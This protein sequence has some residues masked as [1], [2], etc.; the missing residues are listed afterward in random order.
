MLALRALFQAIRCPPL[1][2]ETQLTDNDWQDVTPPQKHLNDRVIRLPRG[3]V[4]GGC[5]STKGS[6]AGSARLLL[7]DLWL[8]AEGGL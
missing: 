1:F 6:W 4:L 2:M 7:L 3:K 5:S 8:L